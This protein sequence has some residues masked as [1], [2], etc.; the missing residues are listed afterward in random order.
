M[1][2][3]VLKE[4]IFSTF[5]MCGGML[6]AIW[7]DENIH[8]DSL[9]G[10]AFVAGATITRVGIGIIDEALTKEEDYENC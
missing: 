3:K 9:L 10:S 1:L 8:D 2:S 4:F 7:V 6:A 5:S